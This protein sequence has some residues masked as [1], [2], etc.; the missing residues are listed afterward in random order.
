MLKAKKD[1][2]QAETARQIK[3]MSI[4][5]LNNYLYTVYLKGYADGSSD[6]ITRKLQ[7]PGPSE[8]RGE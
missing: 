4:P 2:I 1:M 7:T 5:M 3:A 6:R 8:T